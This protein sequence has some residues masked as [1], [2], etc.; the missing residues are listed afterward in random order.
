[1]LLGGQFIFCRSLKI[2]SHFGWV[3]EQVCGGHFF[4][5][6]FFPRSTVLLSKCTFCGPV[7]SG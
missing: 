6:S 3:T 1:M 4:F 5:F 2:A 7:A